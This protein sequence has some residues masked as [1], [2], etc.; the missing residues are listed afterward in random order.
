MRD[1]DKLQ[2]LIDEAI[3]MDKVEDIELGEM[4]RKWFW[5]KDENDIEWGDLTE[6]SEWSIDGWDDDE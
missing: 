6:D 3:T 1:L 4:I 5:S 2:E